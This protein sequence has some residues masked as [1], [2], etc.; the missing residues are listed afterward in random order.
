MR[1]QTLLLLFFGALA[2]A[3]IGGCTPKPDLVAVKLPDLGTDPI[4]YCN[5][6]DDGKLIV[7]VTN[8]GS[9]DAPASVTRV[10]F[11]TLPT[12]DHVVE[13][14]T[15]ALAIGNSHDLDPIDL[16]A[17]PSNCYQANCHFTIT[18]DSTNTVDESDEEDNSASGYCLG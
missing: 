6:D 9:S 8:Q 7:T 13:L 11:T 10:T 1:S 14:A 12:G 4:V 15:P 3:V 16:G 17:F 5:L 18:V 2:I